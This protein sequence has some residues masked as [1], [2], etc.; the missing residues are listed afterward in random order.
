M[1]I[2]LV[3]HALVW[4]SVL[5]LLFG[6]FHARASNLVTYQT[7]SEAFQGCQAHQASVDG[8]QHLTSRILHAAGCL[9]VTSSKWYESQCT[10]TTIATGVVN[11]NPSRCSNKS[12]I[13]GV[14]SFHQWIEDHQCTAGET[15]EIITN[16]NEPAN[17]CDDGC[18]YEATTGSC[19]ETS[20]F[21]LFNS[22]KTGDTC[23]FTAADPPHPPEEEDVPENCV[24]NESTGAISCNCGTGQNEPA[25][26]D[27]PPPDPNDPD[28]NVPPNCVLIGGTLTCSPPPNPTP[29]PPPIPDIDEDA[30]DPLPPSPNPAP[31][32][33]P[34]DNDPDTPDNPG[35]GDGD[36]DG[37]GDR[38]V[39]C[40]PLSNSDCGFAGSATG[41]PNCDAAPS[42]SGDPVA[43]ANLYQTWAAMCYDDGDV[44]NPGDCQLEFQCSGDVL[45]CESIRQQRTQFCLSFVGD[46][47]LDTNVFDDDD[48]GQTVFD[49]AERVDIPT[50]LDY[51]GF[52]GSGSCPA[53][54]QVNLGFI[55]VNV[56]FDFMCDLALTAR[57]FVL[58][59]AGIWALFIVVRAGRN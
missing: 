54:R 21:C 57:P 18:V 35:D 16:V 51:S 56:P 3:A 42:C 41:V 8:Y 26:C 44:T 14:P 25:W 5:F 48:F 12:N 10:D 20:G 47:T 31:T 13:G 59:S 2:R 4:F 1:F 28:P 11:D 52:A 32:N 24:R 55:S 19:D 46:G 15:S 23:P 49:T 50:S 38:D 34:G 45:L 17:W 53:P 22:E 37:D 36:T 27:N 7:Q 39:D 58:I 40:N 29:D 6:S 33:P 30:P 43:C 9:E